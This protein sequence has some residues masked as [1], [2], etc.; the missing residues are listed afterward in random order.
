M[1]DFDRNHSFCLILT[2][3]C[4]QVFG[5]KCR[6]S[7]SVGNVTLTVSKWPLILML[8]GRYVLIGLLFWIFYYGQS[9]ADKNLYSLIRMNY[10]Y[11]PTVPN[12]SQSQIFN[13]CLL[14]KVS[15]LTYT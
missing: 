4:S 8:T 3:L 9:Y 15:N 11:T 5:V 1:C 10:L 6:S 2:K 13:V 12:S 7:S 14:D